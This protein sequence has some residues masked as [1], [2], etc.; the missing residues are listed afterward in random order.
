MS[1]SSKLVD[2]LFES[3]DAGVLTNQAARRIERL[4]QAL[5]DLVQEAIAVTKGEQADHTSE[6][7]DHAIE[8]LAG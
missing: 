7:V 1:K 2:D 8:V 3:D 6:V 4:E 5:E